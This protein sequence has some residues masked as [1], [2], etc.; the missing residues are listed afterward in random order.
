MSHLVRSVG[1]IAMDDRTAAL[2]PS[3]VISVV[4]DTVAANL[5]DVTSKSNAI[6]TAFK[7]STS[8]YERQLVADQTVFLRS[9]QSDN[10]DHSLATS[11]NLSFTDRVVAFAA[12]S[13]ASLASSW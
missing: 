5:T 13:L 7:F 9:A 3:S 10:S 12:R 6:A 2:R 4:S 11:S 8:I 1:T